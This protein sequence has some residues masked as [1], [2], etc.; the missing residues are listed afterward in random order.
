MSCT[1]IS[2]CTSFTKSNSNVLP[3]TIKMFTNDNN[4]NTP[5]W[6]YT[7][8]SGTTKNITPTNNCIDV[9]I[10]ANLIIKGNIIQQTSLCTSDVRLKTDIEDIP[11]SLSEN[12]MNLTPKQYT[13]IS[14]EEHKLRYGFIAQEVEALFPNLVS[15][16]SDAGTDEA[17]ELTKYKAVNYLE[18]IP[19][20]LLKMQDMQKQ[21]DRLNSQL[22]N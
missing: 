1:N 4:Y 12:L 8:S 20:L 10:N 7:T 13:Y 22:N 3:G 17:D 9:Q 11:L 16:V 15:D 18:I 21:I 5:L 19:I 2:N 6:K 14:D